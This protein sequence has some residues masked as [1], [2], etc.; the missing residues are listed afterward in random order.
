[1]GQGWV[2]APL[3]FDYASA[4][5]FQST[6]KNP[7]AWKTVSGRMSNLRL[8]FL[9]SLIGSRMKEIQWKASILVHSNCLY[10]VV[11]LLC[12]T[13]VCVNTT[14]ENRGKRWRQLTDEMLV[15]RPTDRLKDGGQT[16]TGRLFLY[17]CCALFPDFKRILPA[18][19]SSLS[20]V[21]PAT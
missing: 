17:Y 16:D 21:L 7:K 15:N 20:P 11:L 5:C 12:W 6:Q 1:M 3:A 10:S 19:L 8:S 4:T 13:C 14:K 9:H 18:S 2:D